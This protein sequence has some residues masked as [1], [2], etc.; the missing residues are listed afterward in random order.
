M[1][2]KIVDED[3]RGLGVRVTD[4]SGVEHTVAVAFDGNIQGHSQNGYPDDPAERTNREDEM[5]EQA[6]LYARWYVYQNTD[7]DTLLPRRNPDRIAATLVAVRELDDD[8]FRNHFETL[9]R[10][11]QSY[12]DPDAGRPIE[13]EDDVLHPKGVVYKQDIF[14][15]AD[16]EDV[17][18]YHATFAEHADDLAKAVLGRL[19]EA[20]VFDALANTAETVTGIDVTD[21]ALQPPDELRVFELERSSE[22]YYTYHQG[23]GPARTVGRQEPDRDPDTV[24]EVIPTEHV[25]QFEV[26]RA[27]VL[28]RLLCQVRDSFVGRGIEPPPAYRMLGTGIH[29]YTLK[30]EQFDVY[31]EYFDPEADIDGY[32]YY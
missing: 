10:Q 12:A 29:K 11:F 1:I 8:E 5:V 7:Y 4:N 18:G 28:H 14:L 15:D 2:A 30:Y 25:A 21:D 17:R 13:L 20:D 6:R 32:V 3:D 24:L 19:H 23:D 27:F 22:P 31:P 16:V 26:F 9:R